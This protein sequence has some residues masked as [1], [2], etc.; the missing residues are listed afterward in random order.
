VILR[1]ILRSGEVANLSQRLELLHL[2][3]IAGR[4]GPA[5]VGFEGV[6]IV[7]CPALQPEVVADWCQ[8]M[9]CP[10]VANCPRREDDDQ[11]ESR[12]EGASK[13]FFPAPPDGKGRKD[14]KYGKER[15]DGRVRER[16][17][18][19]QQ[20]ESQPCEQARLVMKLLRQPETGG[21]EQ[22]RQCVIPD[23]GSGKINGKRIKSPGPGSKRR[24]P[25]TK[26]IFSTEVKRNAGESGQDAVNG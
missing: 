22:A 25:D 17:D 13:P 11:T 26:G 15:Q 23:P 8:S 16:S 5:V 1:Q 3:W 18:A 12:D 6:A 10:V 24:G 21:E 20:A 7:S 19:V 9:K 14:Q 4:M 2:G